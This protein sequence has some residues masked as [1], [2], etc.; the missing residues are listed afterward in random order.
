MKIPKFLSVIF[1][2]PSTKMQIPKEIQ[3]QDDTGDNKKIQEI[4][5]KK[6]QEIQIQEE[7]LGILVLREKHTKI[8]FQSRTLQGKF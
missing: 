4:R 8:S 3:I 6:I 7:C 1:L 2:F 5:Y